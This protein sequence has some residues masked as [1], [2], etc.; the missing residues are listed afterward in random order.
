M[1][2]PSVASRLPVSSVVRA[3]PRQDFLADPPHWNQYVA[4]GR[5]QIRVLAA[6]T[7][8]VVASMLAL[9]ASGLLALNVPLMVLLAATAGLS[10]MSA[11]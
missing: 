5:R 6:A 3:Q 8:L 1:L 4:F 11:P 10:S 9:T 2:R 7:L